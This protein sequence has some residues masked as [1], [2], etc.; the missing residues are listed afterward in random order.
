[1]N[2]HGPRLRESRWSTAGRRI[3]RSQVAALVASI[4]Q[5]QVADEPTCRAAGDAVP[6]G[7]GER[8]S[9]QPVE[10]D[11]DRAR[12]GSPSTR[13]GGCRRAAV[14]A[15]ACTGGDAVVD[16]AAQRRARG[17]GDPRQAH[18]ADR[19]A[20]VPATAISVCW[21]HGVAGARAPKWVTSTSTRP[22]S[23][24]RVGSTI[25]RRDVQPRLGR[26]T[27]GRREHPLQ[28]DRARPRSAWHTTHTA[29]HPSAAS[30]GCGRRSARRPEIAPRRR[31]LH[32]PAT[33]PK[34]I[35]RTRRSTSSAYET[36]VPATCA[37]PVLRRR[38]AI[39]RT[40]WRR[41]G[42]AAVMRRDA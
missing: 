30:S 25:A 12:R 40:T 20:N 15:H 8:G 1:M 42:I 38:G 24:S 11:R 3:R 22:S 35:R 17:V 37:E 39:E 18:P 41:V 19:S 27:R 29:A 21:C 36:P 5:C 26:L 32:A 7:E 9:T 2:E 16:E 10:R 14:G 23:R 31:R 28:P 33:A 34:R 6:S 13:R 4:E